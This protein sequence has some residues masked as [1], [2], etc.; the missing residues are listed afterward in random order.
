MKTKIEQVL[1]LADDRLNQ[2]MANF[3]GQAIAFVGTSKGLGV[4]IKGEAGYWPLPLAWFHCGAFTR[5]MA[6][7]DQLN[8]YALQI[9][10]EEALGIIGSS[11][12]QNIRESKSQISNRRKL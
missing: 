6:Y 7:A 3:D 5:S 12:L 8:K 2:I 1:E 9:T 11:M 10:E 4:A